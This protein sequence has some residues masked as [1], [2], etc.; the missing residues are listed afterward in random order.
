MSDGYILFE[1]DDKAERA[2]TTIADTIRLGVVMNREKNSSMIVSEKEILYYLSS[3]YSKEEIR[4]MNVTTIVNKVLSI[5]LVASIYPQHRVRVTGTA[6]IL[7]KRVRSV[8]VA[9][10]E[11]VE[12]V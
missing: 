1:G 11:D 12:T 7:S 10:E 6:Q 9:V 5:L 2:A 8:I 4:A 3:I